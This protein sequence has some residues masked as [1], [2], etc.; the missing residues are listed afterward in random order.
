MRG[1]RVDTRE[2][3]MILVDFKAIR[4]SFETS[5]EHGAEW[6]A[7]A[8]LRS[9]PSLTAEGARDLIERY[10]CD[11]G[12]IARRG[13]EL[14][15]FQDLDWERMRIFG[16]DGEPH[17]KR[18]GER[19]RFFRE[20]VQT[21]FERLYEME[22]EPPENLLH[23]TC[24]GYA[25]PSNAQ[26]LVASRG[27]GA[28]TTVTHLYHMGC[29]AAFPAL[30]VAEGLLSRPMAPAGG[31]PRGRVDIVHT[32]LCTLH[33]DPA[34]HEPKDIVVQSLFA[35]GTIR[36]SALARTARMNQGTPAL[37]VLGVLE[38]ILPD[39]EDAMT[40]MPDDWGMSMNLDKNVPLLISSA[41]PAFLDDL[42]AR[43]GLDF[44][45]ER[46]GAAFAVHPGGPRILDLL[47]H[48]LELQPAQ[49]SQSRQVLHD[50]GN[51]S[52]ATLPHIWGGLLEDA[53]IPR[54]RL[55]VS[56]GFGPGLT[57]GGSIGRKI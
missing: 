13:H 25:S 49:L 3:L 43:A 1:T 29:L 46:G 26:R 32:E 9:D 54:G 4:P 35:D 48:K 21:H 19:M 44:H 42:F 37:E 23:V 52:S 5:Q 14:Q 20:S 56:L 22:G 40:W 2:S 28:R 38:R 30:R 10:G 50:C 55:I 45:R 33:L 16:M 24:T 27:W 11:S 34:R 51:M 17:G 7:A 31:T 15:D 12:R 53:G 39:T 18:M 36:Y 8:Y 57:I 41:L 47:E 6:L